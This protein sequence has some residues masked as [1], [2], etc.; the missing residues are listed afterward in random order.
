MLSVKGELEYF[1]AGNRFRLAVSGGLTYMSIEEL[2][3]SQ[4][5][6]GELVRVH[7]A[8]GDSEERTMF[9][10][11]EVSDLLSPPWTDKTVEERVGFLRADLEAFVRG[12]LM[13]MCMLPRKANEKAHFGLLAPAEDG[14]WDVRSVNPDPGLRVVG[15]FAKRDVFVGLC[16]APRSKA[17]LQRLPLADFHSLEWR[18][19]IKRARREWQRLF[20]GLEPHKGASHSDHISTRSYP[21]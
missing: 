7:P 9:V 18:R 12:Q 11:R 14:F 6:A 19:L 17:W 5:D 10:S 1:F 15:A 16:W 20:L 13:G 8:L 21:V 4:L 2:I 3:Q